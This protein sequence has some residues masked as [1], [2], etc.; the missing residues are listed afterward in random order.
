MSIENAIRQKNFRNEYQK[1]T[2]NILY[3]HNWLLERIKNFMSGENIT[4]QQYNILRILKNSDEPLSTMQIREKMID[5]MSDTSRIVDRLLLKALV[6]KKIKET[7]K[8]LVD[9]S[10]TPKGLEVLQ[11][12]DQLNS[13]LDG[14]VSGIDTNEA[15]MLNHLL[16][17]IRR[18]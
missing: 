14:I 1:A 4:L 6:Q 15:Q 13:E 10:I 11:K 3:T 7:D 5:K 16:D 12:I 17:K 2:A 9:I 18:D 8:R